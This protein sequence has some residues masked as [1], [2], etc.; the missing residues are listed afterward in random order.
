M[1]DIIMDVE[2]VNSAE[3]LKD[4]SPSVVRTNV[5]AFRVELRDL[6][7]QRPIILAFGS[8]AHALIAENISRHEYSS[9]VRLTHYSHHI[10][11]E[12]YKEKVLAQISAHSA[13]GSCRLPA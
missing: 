2:R 13:E 7:S 3:L 9:L 12:K 11:K 1:T 5:E 6:G 4:L 10:G 8:A